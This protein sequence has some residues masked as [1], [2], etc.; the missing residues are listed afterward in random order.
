MRQDAEPWPKRKVG[1]QAGEVRARITKA[2]RSGEVTTT[3][4]RLESAEWPFDPVAPPTLWTD[5]NEPVVELHK[6]QTLEE[7]LAT[8]E[9]YNLDG[10]PP[11]PG[12][13]YRM[14]SWWDPGQYD[15][16]TDPDLEWGRG[17]FERSGNWDH[18]HCLLTWATI[19]DGEPGY[20]AL[21]GG[22]WITV[23]SYEKY[24]RDDVLRLRS[25]DDHHGDD[26]QRG[27]QKRQ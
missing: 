17:V 6:L 12:G 7:D 11:Q 25:S 4:L 2:D 16:A 15:A 1:R 3:E 26:G 5:D 13:P 21:P 27:E 24:I 23:E 20:E 18:T 14:Y 22:G 19:S 8:F 10:G 9:S